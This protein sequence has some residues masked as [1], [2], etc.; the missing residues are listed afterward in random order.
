MNFQQLFHLQQEIDEMYS[1]NDRINKDLL[2]SKKILS[3]QASL[4]N[5]ASKTNCFYYW[6]DAPTYEKNSLIS[7][8]NKTLSIILSIGL[9]NNY[10][11]LNLNIKSNNY[12]LTEQFLDL[13]IDISDFFI[14]SSADQYATLLEDFLILGNSLGFTTTELELNFN[15]FISSS[16]PKINILM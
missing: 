12:K 8:Y 2:F 11:N 6:E 9:D 3:L 16:K 13:Y 14:C 5:L 1:I 7:Y 10:T 4:G 15:N